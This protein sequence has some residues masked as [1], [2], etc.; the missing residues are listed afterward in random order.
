MRSALAVTVSGYE[1][2]KNKKRKLNV[3]DCQKDK[4]SNAQLQRILKGEKLTD[5][6][7]HIAQCLIKRQF[8]H[9]QVIALCVGGLK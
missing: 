6:H 2:L 8:T 5:Q 9:T 1:S 3:S 4:D 7:I